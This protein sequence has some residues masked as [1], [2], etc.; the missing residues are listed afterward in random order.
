MKIMIKAVLFD[1][2]GTLLDTN[3]LILISFKETFK[4]VLNTVP[5]D[6]EIRRLFGKPLRESLRSFSEEKE[7]EL[8]TLYR[9]ISGSKHDEMCKEF[10][11]VNEMLRALKNMGIKLGIVT[12]KRKSLALRGMGLSNIVDLFDVIITPSDTEKHK[13]NGEP[14]IEA[15]R[16]IGVDPKEA[17][18]VGDA[19]YDI[20]CGKNAG[21]ITIGVRYTTIPLQ[22]L[23]DTKPDHIIDEPSDIIKIVENYN[24]K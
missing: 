3:E 6:D 7:E 9:E 14:A 24:K 23:L 4:R 17:I 20:L 15:C 22:E 2:D 11:G 18:M 1:L 8:V 12:S 5:S 13:P 10:K 19:T 21:C 16:I